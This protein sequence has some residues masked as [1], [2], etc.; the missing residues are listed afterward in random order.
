MEVEE[1]R[2]G[3]TWYP[4]CLISTD[5]LSREPGHKVPNGND[6]TG[7]NQ[8]TP[9]ALAD[10]VHLGLGCVEEPGVQEANRRRRESRA[11]VGGSGVGAPAVPLPPLGTMDTPLS[12]SVPPF[13]LL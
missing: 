9:T 6:P 12:L 1:A 5:F 11:G 2:V 8:G 10:M 4:E 3:A 7:R 13:S